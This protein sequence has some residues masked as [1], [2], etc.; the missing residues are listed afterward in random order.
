MD[1]N[2]SHKSSS[3]H[4]PGQDL[5]DVHK[6]WPKDYQSERLDSGIESY[7]SMQELDRY[8]STTM[9]NYSHTETKTDTTTTLSDNTTHDRKIS[10]SKSYV[11]F[12]YLYVP[13]MLLL[14]IV[15]NCYITYPQHT[16]TYVIFFVC[17]WPW[18]M[19][20]WIAQWPYWWRSQGRYVN[21]FW[22]LS[23]L[24]SFS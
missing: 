12:T 4:R 7:N 2:V 17:S 20:F 23:C 3:Y 18:T 21:T 8:P 9:D 10:K 1:H 19:W 11:Y 6:Q 16:C 22:Y 15:T 13:F 14:N 24:F 5:P